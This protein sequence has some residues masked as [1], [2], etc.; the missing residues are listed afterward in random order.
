MYIWELYVVLLLCRSEK[1]SERIKNLIEYHTYAVYK[2][3][4]RGL[5][6]KHKL[7]LSLQVRVYC[8]ELALKSL[9]SNFNL[10]RVVGIL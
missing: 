6:E 1:I 5:F 10:S 3:T 7:L 9:P 8:N 4:T 2:Y